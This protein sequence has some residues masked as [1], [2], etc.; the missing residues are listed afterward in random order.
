VSGT[1]TQETVISPITTS[2]TGVAT[3]TAG[4]LPTDPIAFTDPGSDIRVT[5]DT[6]SFPFTSKQL[7]ER[8]QA[9][10]IDKT[11]SYW[12]A[13]ASKYQSAQV[14]KFT[15]SDVQP[16]EGGDYF[17]TV[18][19]NLTGITSVAE[20]KQIFNQCAPATN[21]N[22]YPY[23][24]SAKSLVF[25]TKC[26]ATATQPNGCVVAREKVQPTLSVK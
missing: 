12:D 10:G 26:D 22:L 25:V 18:V 11:T 3:T 9:C 21:Y 8:A 19:P 13:I 1:S 16:H 24:V 7:A 5:R 17:V 23:F 6:I 4:S 2:S 15:F 20:L 14:T